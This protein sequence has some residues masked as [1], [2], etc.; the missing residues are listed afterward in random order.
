MIEPTF[1]VTFS[2]ARRGIVFVG[3]F[4]LLQ[5]GWQSCRGTFVEHLVVH[6][7]TIR[8]AAVVV[9]LLT[10]YAHAQASGFTLN[11][12]GGGLVVANG[13]EGTE[14]LFLLFAAFA[15]APLSWSARWRGLLLGTL[16]VFLINQVRLL[17]LFYAYRKD[18]SLFDSLHDG[19]APIGVII[20]VSAYFYAWLVY[21]V[22]RTPSTG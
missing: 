1:R 11:A 19:A 8:P 18:P 6:D 3:L 7:A 4:F 9:N 17:A 22:P 2:W 16:V 14:A 5:F 20:V 21:N 10:P 15:V 12:V 13:C